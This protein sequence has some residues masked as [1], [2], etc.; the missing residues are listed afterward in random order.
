M[1]PLSKA[2]HQHARI[3]GDHRNLDVPG[4]GRDDVR[5]LIAV[6]ER[7]RYGLLA[8]RGGWRIGKSGR[9]AHTSRA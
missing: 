3:E 6:L 1:R 2:I 7:G 4:L 9:H 8:L 5:A